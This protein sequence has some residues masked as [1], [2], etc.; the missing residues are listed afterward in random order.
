MRCSSSRQA[1][2]LACTPVISSSCDSLKSVV[3]CGWVSAAPSSRACGDSASA[4]DGVARR[5]SFSMPRRSPSSASRARAFK[6]ADFQQLDFEQ[7]RCVG[8]NHPAGAARAV[9]ESGRDGE[10]ARA[11][12]LHPL[13]ALVPALD[14]HAGAERE[15]E[16]LAAILARIELAALDHPIGKPARVVHG[17][18]LAFGRSLA[19]ARSEEHTSELQSLRHLVCRLLLEKKKNKQINN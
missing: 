18:V 19:A 17:Y 11:A 1:S 7:K 2:A 15:L 8:R 16:R 9:A 4:P 14:H 3:M 6:S 5:L 13:H 12:D 10:Q